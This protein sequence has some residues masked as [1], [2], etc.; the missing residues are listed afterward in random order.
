[1]QNTPIFFV[2]FGC[3]IRLIVVF[4]CAVAVA[5]TPVN[6]NSDVRPIL[7]DKCFKCHGPDENTRK[8]DLR[9]D[10]L[11]EA[12]HLLSQ[13]DPASSELLRRI[14]S[15]DSDEQMPP[16]ESKLELSQQEMDAL[17]RWIKSGAPYARHWAFEPVQKISVPSVKD[18]GW[19]KN[20]IDFF[21]L[22]DNSFTFSSIW[23]DAVEYMI[24][25]CSKF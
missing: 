17:T 24:A 14:H 25:T 15:K 9:L 7:S 11:E 18:T 4:S 10:H 1:M 8:A 16:P 22:K 6:F 20:E 21:I 3:L 5:D 19:P 12:S 2:V 23:H 13:D